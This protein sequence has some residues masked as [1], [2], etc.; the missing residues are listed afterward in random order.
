MVDCVIE[1]LDVY[2]GKNKYLRQHNIIR[3][4]LI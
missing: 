2:K 3:Q 4:T 1:R